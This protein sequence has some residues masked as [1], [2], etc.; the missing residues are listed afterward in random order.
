L[1]NHP[2]INQATRERMLEARGIRGII[3]LPLPEAPSFF[4]WSPFAVVGI[5]ENAA[6]IGIHYISYDH[7]HAIETAYAQLRSR[8]YRNIGFCNLAESESRNRHLFFAAYMKCRYLDGL[9]VYPPFLFSDSRE[10]PLTWSR[11]HRLDAV[12]AQSGFLKQLKGSSFSR[13]RNRVRYPL[14]VAAS[15][16]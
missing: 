2:E 10:S 11:K 3:L 12:L 1:Q 5:G 16:L 13:S 15:Q 14:P 9:E 4:D 8:G 7:D 6:S